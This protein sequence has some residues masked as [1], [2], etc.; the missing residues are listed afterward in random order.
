MITTL[1]RLTSSRKF[2]VAL[3]ITLA[4]IV[5]AIIGWAEWAE[6][7]ESA[8]VLFGAYIGLTAL[9]D[10]AAKLKGNEPQG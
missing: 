4:H 3:C 8:Q 7:F 6:V 10:S 9:E 5:G 1:K 2:V